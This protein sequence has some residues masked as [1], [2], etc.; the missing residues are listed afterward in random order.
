MEESTGQED[1][2]DEEGRGV[3]RQ[4]Q[5]AGMEA[6]GKKPWAPSR[7]SWTG[8]EGW[9]VDLFTTSAGSTGL[10][11]LCRGMTHSYGGRRHWLADVRRKK[12]TKLEEVEEKEWLRCTLGTLRSI[13]RHY[14][15]QVRVQGRGCAAF[16]RP[17]SPPCMAHVLVF[18]LGLAAIG[19][20]SLLRGFILVSGLANDGLFEQ[21]SSPI[22]KAKH[23]ALHRGGPTSSDHLLAIW[24]SEPI[25]CL[26]CATA[27]QLAYPAPGS[28]KWQCPYLWKDRA[29]RYPM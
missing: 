16:R 6:S 12:K 4:V 19:F 3:T 25:L 8:L 10:A 29:A 26:A 17:T 1:V 27:R 15:S 28:R 18:C 23:C 7:G 11:L 2:Q 5:L 24:C 21:R 9:A 20:D 13:C 22:P 14:A